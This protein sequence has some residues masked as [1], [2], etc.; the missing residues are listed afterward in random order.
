MIPGYKAWQSFWF[1]SQIEPARLI[2]LRWVLFGLVAYDLWTVMLPHASR[3]GAGNFN[4]AQIVLFDLL[5]PVPTPGVVSAIVLITSMA[6]AF[7]A[8][9]ILTKAMAVTS[10]VG[11]FGLYLWSQADSYQ[12]HY[13]IGLMLL[14]ACLLPKSHLS[15]D[16]DES[17]ATTVAHWAIPLLYV[18]VAIVYFWTAITKIDA[19]WLT[20]LTM[21]QLTAEP[22]V[23][24]A[25]VNLESTLGLQTGGGYKL[26]ATLVVL[27]EFFAALVFLVPKL[28]LIGLLIVP[29]FHVG[30]ELL[31][32][33]IELF[34]YYMIGLNLILLSPPWLWNQLGDQIKKTRK[35]SK[36][37][38]VWPASTPMAV[39]LT[40]LTGVLVFF[41][42]R[43]IP[44]A[45]GIAVAS[46][47]GALT[48][49][50]LS[51]HAQRAT[52]AIALGCIMSTGAMTYTIAANE[53]AYDFYRL[54][55]GDLRRRNKTELAIDKYKRANRIKTSG[56]A[57]HLQQGEL[58]ERLGE[59]EEANMAFKRAKRQL[60][61][62]VNK[63]ILLS[64]Q[65][66]NDADLHLEI[67]ENQL[68]LEQ[69]CRAL[70][71]TLGHSGTK[72]EQKAARICQSNARIGAKA[73]LN[74]ARK[75]L[76]SPNLAQRKT[77]GRIQRQLSKT[78]R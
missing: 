40:L 8:I 21:S 6:C 28:R 9:G 14:I 35:V 38:M 50:A 15:P 7:T 39:L 29:W 49:Y 64:N 75:Q 20:G 13:L 56:P 54:W 73:S 36:G 19:T 24:D 1:N 25:I 26:A 23:R 53:S 62:H 72:A 27:G 46:I 58:H 30:V 69:R 55:G 70:T 61:N 77:I 12:H 43:T 31:G 45:S 2:L 65:S 66:P 22:A 32:V 68:R 16:V 37:L 42:L 18:Q 34:S 59:Y 51:G 76:S 41:L 67:S 10:C 71:R 33:D 60:E 11:Y 57:R 4:V 44:M 3:Y 48:V 5:L 78:V 47:G 17:S 74:K 63:L 52:I